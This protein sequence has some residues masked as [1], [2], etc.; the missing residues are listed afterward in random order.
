MSPTL[1]EEKESYTQARAPQTEPDVTVHDDAEESIFSQLSHEEI[2]V[3]AYS[4]WMERGQPEG[5]PEEDWLRA[6]RELRSRRRNASTET[7]G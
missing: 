4:F 1:V 7:K 2:A 3:L 5:S 6:E